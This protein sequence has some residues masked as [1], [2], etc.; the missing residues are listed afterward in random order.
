MNEKESE[1]E[2]NQRTLESIKEIKERE[3]VKESLKK[4]EEDMDVEMGNLL[5]ILDE[6][7][8]ETPYKGDEDEIKNE[9]KFDKQLQESE[10]KFI[11]FTFILNLIFIP[12]VWCL[13]SHFIQNR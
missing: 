5:S 9:S 10:E 12:F 6:M 2:L 11:K 1:E 4:I 7:G 13:F 8:E 3:R